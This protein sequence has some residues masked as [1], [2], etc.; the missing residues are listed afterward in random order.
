MNVEPFQGSKRIGG[1][2]FPGVLRRAK[3]SN[4]F[5][6][7]YPVTTGMNKLGW[8]QW[9]VVLAF[10]L[11]VQA[12]AEILGNLAWEIAGLIVTVIL[13][14]TLVRIYPPAATEER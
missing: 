11:V 6:V 1:C 8:R 3:L 10:V 9:L 14:W 7:P 4:A 13:G 5:G 2:W 12:I